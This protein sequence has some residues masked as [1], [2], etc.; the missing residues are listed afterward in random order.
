MVHYSRAGAIPQLTESTL[1]K[2]DHVSLHPDVQPE[3][4]PS[5]ADALNTTYILTRDSR[6][7]VVPTSQT[8]SLP[9]GYSQL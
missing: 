2:L 1:T 7:T 9:G 4:P 5:N 6:L 8:N 3:Y